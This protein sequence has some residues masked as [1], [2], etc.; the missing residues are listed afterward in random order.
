MDDLDLEANWGQVAEDRPALQFNTIKTTSAT[1]PSLSTGVGNFI[2]GEDDES[3][4]DDPGF[5]TSVGFRGMKVEGARYDVEQ[6][7]L[8]Y[9]GIGS[10]LLSSK[11]SGLA[12]KNVK[13]VEALKQVEVIV[14]PEV[15]QN[16]YECWTPEAAIQSSEEKGKKRGH[17]EHSVFG[18]FDIYTPLPERKVRAKLF[19]DA[20]RGSSV[21]VPA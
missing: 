3:E 8:N 10:T 19:R 12:S 6:R 15:D 9:G 1:F 20:K 21:G 13:P 7:V 5:S 17:R 16:A 4:D 18:L 14:A 2:I 11:I